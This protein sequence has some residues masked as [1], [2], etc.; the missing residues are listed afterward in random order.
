MNGIKLF[1]LVEA[2]AP[3]M[4]SETAIRHAALEWRLARQAWLSA[5]AEL[6]PGFTEEQVR[7]MASRRRALTEGLADTR[8]FQ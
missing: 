5:I 2:L 7:E 4:P 8:R 1:E 3:L 6:G